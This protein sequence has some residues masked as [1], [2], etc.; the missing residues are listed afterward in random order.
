M[1]YSVVAEDLAQPLA[2]LLLVLVF[3]RLGL[4]VLGATAAAVLSFGL[5]AALVLRYLTRLAPGLFSADDS[6]VATGELIRFALPTSL[7]GTLSL[8]AMWIDLLFVGYFRPGVDTGLYMAASQ[9]SFLFAVVLTSINAVFSP[10]I[11]DLH[12]RGEAD[13]LAG[14]FRTSTRWGLLLCTPLFVALAANPTGLLSLLMG[15]DYVD[16]ARPMLILACGQMVNLATGA[17]G[18]LLVMSG[19]PALWLGASA[20]AV[21]LNV[22]LNLALI[23]RL[24]LTGAATATTLSLIGLFGS[25][26]FLVRRELGLW[27]YDRSFLR[28]VLGA[29]VA[30]AAVVGIGRIGGLHDAGQTILQLAVAAAVFW[31][32][33]GLGGRQGGLG[34]LL[35]ALRNRR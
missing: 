12:H 3:H 17:V 18:F 29:A 24:G 21:A 8:A 14:L 33:A 10:M 6:G 20:A 13:R 2:Q 28:L 30:A 34:E 16:G 15:A 26:L 27:P 32:V 19:R 5:A 25:G 22:T 1:R 23:P 11:A 31:T 4:A 35:D 9:I 7:A